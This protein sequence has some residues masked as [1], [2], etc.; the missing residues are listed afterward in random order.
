MMVRYKR[1]VL[2]VVGAL[3][4]LAAIS[5]TMLQRSPATAGG[6]WTD[7][8]LGS[9]KFRHSLPAADADGH[10]TVDVDYPMKSAADVRGAAE[11]MNQ[12]AKESLN[13]KGS[14]KATVVFK[15]PLTVAEFTQFAKSSGIAPIGSIVRAIQPDGQ[16]VTIGAPPVWDTD[17]QG[18]PK[19]GQPAPNN[20]PFD[21][22]GFDRVTKK[23]LESGPMAGSRVLGVIS[24]DLTLDL[25]TYQNI[26]RSP[27]VFAVDALQEVVK[28]AIQKRNPG[29]APEKIHVRGS[30]LYWGMED[31]GIVSSK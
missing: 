22:E 13:S 16:R 9:W 6:P 21:T 4:L 31:S 1:R 19:I 25:R 18:R 30:Q 8:S 14:L 3:A 23:I 12:H 7:A 17:T 5:A 20:A 2:G 26:E 11:A 27:D 28:E 29:A 15:R 10:Y 24:S